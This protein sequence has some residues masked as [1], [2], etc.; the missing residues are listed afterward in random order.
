M[1]IVDDIH[2]AAQP[3]LLLLRHLVRTPDLDG[4]LLVATYRDTK[5]E[6]GEEL[7]E[8]LADL[9]RVRRVDRCRLAGVDEGAVYE[10]LVHDAGLP[11]SAGT[12]ALA[13]Q[14][15]A[16]TDGNPFFVY[17]LIRHLAELG[18]LAPRPEHPGVRGEVP[19]SVR[20]VVV[21]RLAALPPASEDVLTA[22][23]VI[24]RHFDVGLLSAV[25]D[26]DEDDTLYILDVA[27]DA[28]L[29]QETGFDEYRFAH[30]LV[31]SALYQPLTETRR[32]RLH[33]RVAEALE[34]RTD[35]RREQR[36]PQLAHHFLEA[37][38]AGVAAK[39]VRYAMEASDAASE[40][41]AFEDAANLCRRALVALEIARRGDEYIEA[42]CECDLVLRLGRAEL[43]ARGGPARATPCCA[44]SRS[45]AGWAIRPA[46][47]RPSSRSIAGSSPHGSYGP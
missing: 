26:T 44:R 11:G 43:R 45:P 2:W 39:S 27:L 37:A 25:T 5:P 22:A 1:L 9:S 36:L 15:H 12:E 30:A 29:V 46:W 33:R 40:S 47:P 24:G 6:R 35:E 16:E 31:Q 7:D 28:H 13:A 8:F 21:Q 17:E 42:T 20:D 41:L 4:L 23:A 38:P 18:T 19:P 3:T 14:I 10:L 34:Q 32:V